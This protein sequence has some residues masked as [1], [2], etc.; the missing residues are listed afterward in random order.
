MS[1]LLRADTVPSQ[2]TLKDIISGIFTDN[3]QTKQQYLSIIGLLYQAGINLAIGAGAFL[4]FVFMRPRNQRV[5]ARRYKALANDEPPKISK[6]IFAWVPVLWRAD[7]RFLLDTVDIDS[8][9]FLRF[10]KLGMWLMAIFGFLGMCIIVPV[11]FSNG[12]N[13]NV[14]GNLSEFAL[15]WITLYHVTNLKVFS[16]HIIAAYMFTAIFFYFIIREYK[17]YIQ[18]KQEHFASQ[19]YL[20]K[21]QSRTLM[22]T[23]VPAEMQSDTALNSFVTNA[24]SGILP[25]QVSIARKIGELQEMVDKHEQVVRKLEKV[26]AKYLVGDYQSK[27]RPKVKVSGAYVDAIEHYTLEIES[28][29]ATINQARKE[30]ETFT[31]TSVGFVSYNSP[32]MAHE[33]LRSLKHLRPAL[34]AMAPHPRDIIWSNAQ[35]PKSKRI[36]RLWTARFLSVVICFIAFWPVAA[37]TFIGSAVNIQVLWPETTSFFSEHGTLTTIWQNTFSPLI[38][39]LYYILIPH[40]F[41]AISRYQGISTHTGVER[42]VLKKMYVFYIL[43]NLVVLTLVGVI[44]TSV[45]DKTSF[46]EAMSSFAHNFIQSLNQKAQFWTAYVSIKAMNAMLEFAQLISLTMIFF[47][48]YTRDLTPRELRDVT[49]PPD[50]DY[51][52]VYSLYLWVFTI[53]MF[54]SVYSPIVLPFAFLDYVLAYWVYKYAIMYVYQT[55]HDSGGAMWRN[56]INRMITSMVIFQV[57]LICCLKVRIDMFYDRPEEISQTMPVVYSLIPLPVMTAGLGIYLE[58]WLHPK[59]TYMNTTVGA[60]ELANMREFA[61]EDANAEDTLGDRFLHPTFS[62]QLATPMVDRRIKHLL[63]RVYRGRLSIGH[64]PGGTMRKG[65]HGDVE[66]KFG[67]SIGN[68]STVFGSE[69]PLDT[70]TMMDARDRRD[71]DGAV[72]PVP[73][74][75]FSSGAT[76]VN[77]KGLLRSYSASSDRSYGD[78]VEMMRLGDGRRDRGDSASSSQADLLGHAQGVS[79]HASDFSDREM[80]DMVLTRSNSSVNRLN[81]G[82]A[83]IAH[84]RDFDPVDLYDDRSNNTSMG[85][86]MYLAAYSPK[87]AADRVGPM[88]PI[89][90]ANPM[91][92]QHQRPAMRPPPS[93]VVVSFNDGFSSGSMRA[94]PYGSARP[95]NNSAPVGMAGL[96]RPRQGFTGTGQQQQQMGM[97]PRPQPPPAGPQRNIPRWD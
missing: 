41:R 7:E 59:V 25:N 6:G 80:D 50:F 63:P 23:R 29:E 54:Y 89:N 3:A 39:A 83:R 13:E 26:F 32:L 46:K 93:N 2:S 24:S 36:T 45:L 15:L 56:V 40:V 51:S 74:E 95:P 94:N 1:F 66:S 35:M 4:V 77:G 86:E 79:G 88:N 16:V 90:P 70:D 92:M 65:M 19:R 62:Q 82:T 73:F 69:G 68:A 97:G 20:R 58:I 42:S 78:N 75:H 81:S 96:P 14:T 37:L 52:P 61:E 47:K 21:L 10:L 38:L 9:F 71:F 85:E 91:M 17:R 87:N 11:T 12:N 33:A 44:V 57:Y 72:T 48:R 43:S 60:D 84:D 49:K 34:A 27:P 67:T 31:S 28:L 55:R 30:T 22:V 5:Y 53:S 18:V 76:T 64:K 8:V